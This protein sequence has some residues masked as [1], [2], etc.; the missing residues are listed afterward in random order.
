MIVLHTLFVIFLNSWVC[1]VPK[2]EWKF[3]QCLYKKVLIYSQIKIRSILCRGSSTLNTKSFIGYGLWMPYFLMF[4]YKIITWKFGAANF[5]RKKLNI[6]IFQCCGWRSWAGFGRNC[7][8]CCRLFGNTIWKAKVRN[9]SL[10]A[11]K[12]HQEKMF[13]IIEF[14]F[15]KQWKKNSLLIQKNRENSN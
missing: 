8:S 14:M 13:Y 7:R 5:A 11:K 9:D 3:T 12:L 6:D 4:M 15:Q 1:F 2:K 10:Y